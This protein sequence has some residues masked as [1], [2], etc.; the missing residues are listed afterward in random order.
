MEKKQ[1]QQLFEKESRWQKSFEIKEEIF[2]DKNNTN[3]EIAE[4]NLRLSSMIYVAVVLERIRFF[5]YSANTPGRYEFGRPILFDA[6][7]FFIQEKNAS[8]N[9]IRLII[10]NYEVSS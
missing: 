3:H 7:I 5:L 6:R 8:F 9:R 4:E 1:D 2:L 10:L